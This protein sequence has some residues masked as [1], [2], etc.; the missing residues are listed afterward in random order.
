MHSHKDRVNEVKKLRCHILNSL[1]NGEPQ[2]FSDSHANQKIPR[3][4]LFDKITLLLPL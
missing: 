3:K 4:L 1:L 2:G